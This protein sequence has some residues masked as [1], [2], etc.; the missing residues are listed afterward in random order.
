[1]MPCF[2]QHRNS[3]FTRLVYFAGPETKAETPK[4]ETVLPEIQYDP[5]KKTEDAAWG[6]INEK[7]GEE[8]YKAIIQDYVDKI[9]P[10][11]PD[12][13][14][15]ALL[16]TSL[17][18]YMKF[19]GVERKRFM[20][21]SR[22][23]RSKFDTTLEHIKDKAESELKVLKLAVEVAKPMAEFKETMPSPE[24][25][26]ELK[27]YFEKY[28]SVLNGRYFNVSL[29]EGVKVPR[30]GIPILNP[31]I[32]ADKKV[33]DPQ[34][35]PEEKVGVPI[36][37]PVIGSDVF[38]GVA[39]ETASKKFQNGM[40]RWVDTKLNWL[41][42]KGS[43]QKDLEAFRDEITQ[44][45][46]L[47]SKLDGNSAILS[48]ADMAVLEAI[49]FRATPDAV[50]RI[51]DE[52]DD[53]T[54]KRL[55]VM[56]LL[57]PDGWEETVQSAGNIIIKAAIN[58]GSEN[59]FVTAMNKYRKVSD[60]SEAKSEF[61]DMLG[62]ISKVGVP[63]TLAFLHDF[64]EE[65]H[66]D[67]LHFEKEVQPPSLSYQVGRQMDYLLRGIL[68][69]QKQED[70][71]IV[72]FMTAGLSERKDI[73]DNDGTRDVLFRAIKNAT[74]HYADIYDKQF[75]GI[76]DDVSKLHYSKYIE[77]PTHD[78]QAAQLQALIILGNQAKVIVTHLSSGPKYRG[79]GYVEAMENAQVPEDAKSVLTGLKFES[80][81]PNPAHF[82]SALDRGGFNTRDLAL[83]GAKVLGVLTVA[84]NL[85]QS[86]SETSGDFMDRVMGTVE[87]AA[88][89]QGFLAGA[90]VAVGTHM[91]ERNPRFLKYP[92]LSQH[93]RSAVMTAFKLDNLGARIGGHEVQRFL[94]NNAEWRALSAP[95]IDGAKVKELLKQA[96]ER[97]NPGEPP[98]ITRDDLE[99]AGITDQGI[100]TTLTMGGRSGRM[101]YLFYDKFFSGEVKP[102][103]NHVREICTG[104]NYIS[105]SPV[106]STS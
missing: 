38:K 63:E 51:L 65:V 60:F 103:V 44:R 86:Y 68:K 33:L 79:M 85:F 12:G 8:S 18:R 102:D 90:V 49:A 9:M 47:Y 21:E 5:A 87:N 58:G 104:E 35:Y 15:A 62:D 41:I 27:N 17:N 50:G 100:L 73:L 101:R 45:Y 19:Y 10:T 105:P 40:E 66:S 57:N 3:E 24:N 81:T 64:N 55:E 6:L 97:A 78:D 80:S 14:K 75:A 30:G 48:S 2:L 95:T 26:K 82:Q 72:N 25:S 88:T 39:Y 7:Y 4:V 91:A 32:H 31:F 89:N 52:K 1:M 92:W 69:P 53:Q 61:K 99:K 106:K 83:K 37:G 74:V 23:L 76:S 77:K 28:L 98:I 29:N 42:K 22:D 71:M 13:Y 34:T 54:L 46:E 84:S 43:S 11:E 16:A 36:V 20:E 70:Q 96:S 59:K 93:E 56:Q 67:V 94:G